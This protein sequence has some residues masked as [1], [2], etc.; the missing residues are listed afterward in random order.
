MQE[1]VEFAHGLCKKPKCTRSGM[2]SDDDVCRESGDEVHHCVECGGLS[3]ENKGNNCE[4]CGAYWCIDWQQTFI[5]GDEC[6]RSEI[7]D[8][9]PDGM[10]CPQCYFD[11]PKFHCPDRDCELFHSKCLH[12]WKTFC[13]SLINIGS[14][15]LR[16]EEDM[17]VRIK[18]GFARIPP[19]RKT[20]LWTIDKDRVIVDENTK[21]QSFVGSTALVDALKLA[22]E[23]VTHFQA[24]GYEISQHQYGLDL[25]GVLRRWMRK[26]ARDKIPK[27]TRQPAG[28]D[29]SPIRK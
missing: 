20:E 24:S 2:Y 22:V 11:N 1:E 28:R 18:L 27:R 26:Y 6:D 15:T 7:R 21:R 3:W 5:N 4:K 13:H 23:R 17:H 25:Y 12:D 16:K 29:A 8:A 9:L 14:V 19:R 10:I